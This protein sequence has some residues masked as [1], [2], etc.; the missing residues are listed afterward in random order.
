MSFKNTTEAADIRSA[1]G[2]RFHLLEHGP[3]E[4]QALAT[5][6]IFDL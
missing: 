4:L 6:C 5:Y 3:G 1:R 2:H